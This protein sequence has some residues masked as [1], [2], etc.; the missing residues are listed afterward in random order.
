MSLLNLRNTPKICGVV[1]AGPSIKIYYLYGPLA[2][3]RG[4]T[5]LRLESFQNINYCPKIYV[6]TANLRNMSF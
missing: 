2:C 4:I 6:R 5:A 3:N 1:I